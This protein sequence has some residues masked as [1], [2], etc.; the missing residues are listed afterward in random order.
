MRHVKIQRSF[1]QGA[2]R[3]D[4]FQRLVPFASRGECF[5]IN[6]GTHPLGTG[7]YEGDIFLSSQVPSFPKRMII[8]IPWESFGNP[9]IKN[10]LLENNPQ[11]LHNHHK[12]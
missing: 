5:C 12:T 10:W 9:R 4:K 3:F 6:V 7:V 11:L 2:S 8:E 1:P